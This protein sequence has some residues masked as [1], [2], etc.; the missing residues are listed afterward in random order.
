MTVKG[1]LR[2]G[3][4]VIVPA[5]VGGLIVQFLV[6]V[7]KDLCAPTDVEITSPVKG[8]EVE[9]SPAGHLV[10]GTSRKVGDSHLYV[11]VHPLPTEMW[12]VQ[13]TPTILDGGDWQAIVYFGGEFVGAGDQYELCAIITDKILQEGQTLDDF[14]SYKAKDVI[15]VVRLAPPADNIPPTIET[16]QPEDGATISE[17]K[18]TIGAD[19]IDPSCI[20]TTSVKITVDNM[21]VTVSASV[22]S[23]GITYIPPTAIAEGEH[24]VEVRVKDGA[25]NEATATWSFIIKPVAYGVEVLIS[26]DYQSDVSCTWL[27]YTVT[28]RNTGNVDDTYIL[29]VSDNA[30]WGPIVEPTSLWVERCDNEST[31]TLRI[32][33]SENAIGCTEDLITVIAISQFDPSVSDSDSCIARAMVVRG[34]DVLISPSYQSGV[35]GSV[36]NYTV[37]VT[38]TSNVSD[39]FSLGV[40]DSTNWGPSVSPS[41]LVVPPAENRTATLS[42]TI[43]DNAIVC[44]E[45]SI[46]VTVTSQSDDTVRDLDTCVIHATSPPDEWVGKAEAPEVG[47]YGEAIIGT[48]SHVYIAKCLYATST[49]RFWRYDPSANSWASMSTTGLPTG[50][51]RSGTAL[52]WDNS[53]RIYALCGARYSDS[54]RRVFFRYMIS[55]NSWAQLEDTPGPQGAGDAITWSGY[56]NHIY[57]ILGSSEHGTIFTRHDAASNTWETKASPPAGTD[58]GCSLAW[59]GGTYLYALRGE[60]LEITPLRDFWRYDIVNNSWSSMADIPEEGGVGDGGSLLWIGNWPPGHSDY[61][62]ALGGGS[63]WEDAGDNYY[64][65]SIS[66]NSWEKLT[67]IPYPITYY[68]GNR[69]GFAEGNIYYW[70]GTPSTYLGGGKKFCMYSPASGDE[71]GTWGV[72]QKGSVVEIAYGEGTDFPQYA[73]LHLNDSYFRMVYGPESKWGTSVILLPSFWAG[74]NYY[75][76]APVGCTWEVVGPELVLSITGTISDLSVSE[77]IYVSPPSENS[78]SAVVSVDVDGDVDLDARPGEAFKLAMLSS[79][80]ISENVWDAQSAYVGD[81]LIPLPESEWILQPPVEHSTFSLIGGTSDW[82]VNAPTIGVNLDRTAQVTGWVTPS[83]DPN[84]DSVGFWAASDQII[85]SWQYT[86]IARP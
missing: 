74:G 41:S 67:N 66:N 75:Q 51:F 38:N 3:F 83:T 13:H 57:A 72:T 25:G 79:M 10:T 54:D 76:G 30:G 28:I 68:V 80:H 17:N 14:P 16:L 1:I 53:D 5:I 84:D 22:T 29:S 7:I 78:I 26:P 61:I 35:L 19:Y 45:D 32:H 31:A 11:L 34:V 48:G 44:T 2:N 6:P 63:C 42:V 71:H 37:T 65:Y 69:L 43:P 58:D 9:W 33:V 55:T 8:Q 85:R 86:I 18:P 20:D 62:Y 27:E 70:Q 73:A 50:A 15:T 59:A 21:D 60:Y 4:K 82:K 56:D 12:W 49:P 81:Q 64:R 47:G 40:M 23:T 52:A 77:E 24:T 39:N 46:T 36:L